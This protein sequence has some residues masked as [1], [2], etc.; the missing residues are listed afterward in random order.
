MK[1]LIGRVTVTDGD[2]A[3]ALRVISHFDGLVDHG[4]STAA[5]LRAAAALADAPV[6]LHDSAAGRTTRVD[7]AGRPLS[8]PTP[9]PGPSWTRIVIDRAQASTVW[10]ERDGEPGPLDQ[11]ILERCAQALRA[12]LRGLI[13][14]LSVEKLVRIAC[15]GGVT[16]L[17]RS[18][19]L[20]ALRIT[21]PVTVVTTP[22]SIVPAARARAL[23][24]QTWVALLPDGT[25]TATVVRSPGRLGSACVVDN[26]I[27]RGYQHA[28]RALDLAVDPALG[29]PSIVAFEDLGALASIAEALTP[30]AAAASAEVVALENL[31]TQRPWVPATFYYLSTG[32]SLRQA[33]QALHVHHSTLQDRIDW[34]E[35][36]LGYSP[37]SLDGRVRAAA[38]WAVW[39]ISGR[40]HEER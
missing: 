25:Q 14:P 30:Q 18:D 6:G 11:L 33:A 9:E 4:A 3:T 34:L 29:G 38:A 1:E 15:D 12:R 35:D 5:I 27:P 28:V 13:E 36:L 21:G 16:D 32:L 20:S 39:R 23:S 17:E 24:V 19:A 26:D 22:A 8:E 7:A 2:T 10:L 40:L 37:R 31:R